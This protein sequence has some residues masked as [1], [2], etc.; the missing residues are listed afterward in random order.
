VVYESAGDEVGW[1]TLWFCHHWAPWRWFLT[2]LHTYI[3]IHTYVHTI[4]AIYNT[5]IYTQYT[6]NTHKIH[7]YRHIH[8][9]IH[10][11]IYIYLCMH[12]DITGMSILMTSISKHTSYVFC[13]VFMIFSEM[14]GWRWCIV[15]WGYF[16]EGWGKGF[17][18]QTGWAPWSSRCFQYH[19]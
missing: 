5:H 1:C 6:H 11:Y 15:L 18:R 9:H 2:N 7:T 19:R 13:V 12:S 4:H 16:P 10:I 17:V 3:I 14:P 8:I